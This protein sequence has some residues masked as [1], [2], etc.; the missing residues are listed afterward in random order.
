MV[1]LLIINI[2]EG[3]TYRS[4]IK[5]SLTEFPYWASSLFTVYLVYDARL[6]SDKTNDPEES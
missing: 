1:A 3:I 2:L 5:I 4:G 6:T